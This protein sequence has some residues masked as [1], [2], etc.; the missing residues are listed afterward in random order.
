[1]LD[2]DDVVDTLTRHDLLLLLLL[3]SRLA[4]VRNSAK[5]KSSVSP[6][7]YRHRRSFPCAVAKWKRESNIILL[8]AVSCQGRTY[9]NM[10]HS[11]DSKLTGAGSDFDNLSGEPSLVELFAKFVAHLSNHLYGVTDGFTCSL[12]V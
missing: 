4:S 10:E 3:G 11:I 8:D 2:A 5:L 6:S 12:V 1:M 9:C 7:S